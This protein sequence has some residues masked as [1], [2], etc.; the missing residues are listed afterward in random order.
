MN[1]DLTVEINSENI[2]HVEHFQVW[3]R[4][5]DLSLTRSNVL[6]DGCGS[7]PTPFLRGQKK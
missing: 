4:F 2:C 1:Y 3:D 6:V 7:I 5:G